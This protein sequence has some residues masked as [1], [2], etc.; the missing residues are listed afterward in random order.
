MRKFTKL[1]VPARH[2]LLA[3]L[4]TAAAVAAGAA[5]PLPGQP[6]PAFTLPAVDGRQV[7]LADFRGKYVVLEWN[8][9]H[10]RS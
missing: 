5:P 2:A 4:L 3:G 9:P 1:I 6:A 8:N 7:S 10:C